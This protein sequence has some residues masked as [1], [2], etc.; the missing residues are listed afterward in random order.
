MKKEAFPIVCANCD[1]T[2]VKDE[3][4][5]Y[6]SPSAIVERDGHKIGIIGYVTTKTP[7]IKI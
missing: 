6:I 4:G 1:L 3:L 5:Q 2:E 7:V